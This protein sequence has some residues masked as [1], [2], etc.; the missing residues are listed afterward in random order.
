MNEELLRVPLIAPGDFSPETMIRITIAMNPPSGDNDPLL[1]ITDGANRN[2]FWLVENGTPS[3][4]NQLNP[5]EIINGT[6]N[7]RRAPA[8]NPVAGVYVLLFDPMHRY[9]SCSTNNG[10][11][12]NGKFN[13]QLNGY[14]GLSVVL[15]RNN[16]NEQYTFHYFLIELLQV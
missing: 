12:T 16:A 7:G 9:G 14:N 4:T 2:Q 1:G 8:G 15:H 3:T 5:C 10:F 13:N 11:A 6:F